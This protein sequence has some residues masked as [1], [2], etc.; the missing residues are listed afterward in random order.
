MENSASGNGG[1]LCLRIES[2]EALH[3]LRRADIRA[4]LSLRGMECPMMIRAKEG[5][6]SQCSIASAKPTDGV[7]SKPAC[8]R[9][10]LRVISSDSSYEMQRILF[11][12]VIGKP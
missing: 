11:L 7:T 4:V 3:P 5:S 6:F 12:L 10:I 9:I 1:S 8:S 2:T